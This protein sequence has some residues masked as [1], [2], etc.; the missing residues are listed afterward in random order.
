MPVVMPAGNVSVSR[1][2]VPDLDA[3][4]CVNVYFEDA[5]GNFG[6]TPKKAYLFKPIGK[7]VGLEGGV[8]VADVDE[9]ISNASIAS[10]VNSFDNYELDSTVEGSMLSGE[11]TKDSGDG[12]NMLQLKAY[13]RRKAFTAKVTYH[14]STWDKV[15][16]IYKTETLGESEI[17]GPGRWGEKLDWDPLEYFDMTVPDAEQ[18]FREAKYTVSFSGYYKYQDDSSYVERWPNYRFTENE[19]VKNQEYKTKAP[20][21]YSQKDNTTYVNVYYTEPIPDEHFILDVYMNSESV[22]KPGG[23]NAY[24]DFVKVTIDGT[25]YNVRLVDKAYVHNVSFTWNEES[26]PDYPGAAVFAPNGYQYSD[27]PIL[28]EGFTDVTTKVQ[29]METER[30]G[31]SNY[32]YYTKGE[33][34][35]VVMPDNTFVSQSQMILGNWYHVSFSDKSIV[36]RLVKDYADK[37]KVSDTITGVYINNNSSSGIRQT[38]DLKYPDRAG[39][40]TFNFRAKNTIHLYHYIDGQDCASESG[41]EF[42]EGSTI[43]LAALTKCNSVVPKK[44]YVFAFYNDSAYTKKVTAEKVNVTSSIR[45]YGKSV[46]DTVDYH[47]YAHYELPDSIGEVRYV[48][49]DM[50]QEEGG[51]AY[52][53]VGETRYPLTKTENSTYKKDTIIDG[54]EQT[55]EYDVIRTTYTYNGV[56]VLVDDVYKTYTNSTISCNYTEYETGYEGLEY[57]EKNTANVLN[58]YCE[59]SEKDLAVYFARKTFTLE[60]DENTEGKNVDKSVYRYGQEITVKNA[61]KDG[62]IF[63]G[64]DWS[65]EDKKVTEPSTT[66]ESDGVK[67]A[68]PL[69]NVVLKAK[70]KKDT[71]EYSIM[72]YYQTTAKT[73]N[74]SF[75]DSLKDITPTD[76]SI[77]IAGAEAV[78]GKVYNAEGDTALAVAY[79]DGNTTYYYAGGKKNG[80]TYQVEDSALVMAVEKVSLETELESN[81]AKHV[82][83]NSIFTYTN[84]T[85][86]EDG[87]LTK[88]P[89]SETFKAA[90]GM[91]LEYYYSRKGG[92]SVRLIAKATDNQEVTATLTSTGENGAITY[93]EAVDLTQHTNTGYTFQG[94][95][96]AE[97]VLENTSGEEKAM[98]DWTLKADWESLTKLAAED[99]MGLP[100][101]ND[102]TVVAVYKPV[103]VPGGTISIST[104]RNEYVY[105]YAADT[106][107]NLESNVT[108]EDASVTYI[109]GYTWKLGEQVVGSASTYKF[110]VAMNKGNYNYT[111]TIEIARRDNNRS[112]Y[113]TSSSLGIAVGEYQWDCYGVNYEGIYDGQEH[114]ID[115]SYGTVFEKL[116]EGTDYKVYYSETEAITGEN[117]DSMV[118]AKTAVNKPITKKD[119]KVDADGNVIPYTVYFY[120]KPIGEKAANYMGASGSAYITIHPRAIQA[121]AKKPFIKVFDDD[122]K[123]NGS[124]TT[125]GNDKYRLSYGEQIEGQQVEYYQVVG[126]L[127]ADQAEQTLDFD[128]VYN[129]KHV[130]AGMITLS[131][132]QL[133][134]KDDPSKVNYNYV[135][136]TGIQ[137]TG[138]IQTKELKVVWKDSEGD[139]GEVGKDDVGNTTVTYSY[140]G[141]THLPAVAFA[142]E[143]IT[144]LTISATGAESNSGGHIATAELSSTDEDV[145]V[146]D[147]HISQL[148]C[149][150]FVTNKS[151]VIVP[152]HTTVEYDQKN[153]G[154]TTFVVKKDDGTEVADNVTS[155]ASFTL[156]GVEYALS[157]T[158]VANEDEAVRGYSQAGDYAFK[159]TKMRVIYNGKDVS[160]NF[161]LATE[162]GTLTITKKPVEVRGITAE[163][164]VYNG[165]TNVV[166]GFDTVTFDGIVEGDTLEL[167][168]AQITG[169]F[170][171]KTVDN[172]KEV[173][174]TIPEAALVG[175]SANNYCL[176]TES[177]ASVQNVTATAHITPADLVIGAKEIQMNY[178]EDIPFGV[179]I[180]EELLDKKED[181]SVGGKLTF[182]VTDEEENDCGSISYDLSEIEGCSLATLAD[183]LPAA[184]FGTF[185]LTCGTYNIT[186]DVSEMTC[187]DYTF[188]Q[189]EVSATLTIAKKQVTA[190]VKEGTKLTKVYDGTN[191]VLSSQLEAIPGV[192][193]FEGVAEADQA[194]FGFAAEN[195][196]EAEY[197]DAHVEAADKI[198]LTN[199]AINNDNYELVSTTLDIPAEITPK[200]LTIKAV[201]KSITYGA[202][203]TSIRYS[204]SL[205]DLIT[206][207]ADS[208][209]IGSVTYATD[210][211]NT[212]VDK[213]NAGS[214]YKIQ[215]TGTTLKTKDYQITETKNGTLTVNKAVI[216]VK[217]APTQTAIDE[218]VAN[219]SVDAP[220]AM[221][222]GSAIKGSWFTPVYSGFKYGELQSV[223]TGTVSYR[224]NMPEPLADITVADGETETP[225][226]AGDFHINPVVDGLSASNYRFE[227]DNTRE[228]RINKLN[229][230]LVDDSI[231]VKDKVYD[232]TKTVALEQIVCG[233]GNDGK[234]PGSESYSYDYFSGIQDWDK[235]AL[236]QAHETGLVFD[237]SEGKTEYD[238]KDAGERTVSLSYSL[239]TYM[240]IR[241]NLVNPQPTATSNI[242][243]KPLKITAV[244]DKSEITYGDSIPAFSNKYDS[245]AGDETEAVLELTAESRTGDSIY[246]DAN[247]RAVWTCDYLAQENQYSQVQSYDVIPSGYTV[248]AN[249]NYEVSYEKGTF[250]VKDTKL[251]SPEVTITAPGVVKFGPSKKIGDVDI[252]HYEMELY[253]RT[254]TEDAGALIAITGCKDTDGNA[255]SANSVVPEKEYNLLELIRTNGAG[256]YE[257]RVTAVAK[258]D[259]N[260]EYINVKSSEPGVS[261]A[262]YATEVTLKLD[263]TDV[264][265]LSAKTKYPDNISFTLKDV[266]KNVGAGYPSYVF[267]EGEKDIPIKVDMRESAATGYGWSTVTSTA[268]QCKLK[269]NPTTSFDKDNL[270]REYSD[271]ADIM[272]TSSS[273]ESFAVAKAMEIK[274]KLVA[275][276]AK[277][278]AVLSITNVEE[279]TGGDY[280]YTVDGLSTTIKYNYNVFPQFRI[281]ISAEEGDTVATDKYTY[282]CHWYRKYPGNGN[283]IEYI[284]DATDAIKDDKGVY[285]TLTLPA[286]YIASRYTIACEITAKRNDNDNPIVYDTSV[287]MGPA[288]R[289]V[290]T[291]MKADFKANVKWNTTIDGKEFGWT[292]GE[293][294]GTV[295]TDIT[296]EEV[297]AKNIAY[298]YSNTPDQGSTPWTLTQPAAGWKSQMPTDAGTWYVRAYVVP[299][300]TNYSEGVTDA[301]KFVIKKAKLDKPDES[302]IQLLTPSDTVPYGTLV[303][304]PVDNIYE[305]ASSD[306]ANRA[307]MVTPK[308]QVVVS[309][310]NG[311]TY[312]E[313][314]TYDNL[315]LA[316]GKT[317]L[318][319]DI[320]ETLTQKG[321]YRIAIT[322]AANSSNGK[323]NCENS[324]V[325]YYYTNVGGEIVAAGGIYEKTYDGTP[326]V[327]NAQYEGGVAEGTTYQWYKDGKAVAGAT[328]DTYDVKDV[329]QSGVYFC[330]ATD[331]GNPRCTT[332]QTVTIHKAALTITAKDQQINYKQTP[333]DP[334]TDGL[335]AGTV[336]G[337]VTVNGFVPGE[338]FGNLSGTLKY[339]YLHKDGKTAYNGGKPDPAGEYSIKPSGYTSGNYNITYV[340]GKLTVNPIDD[341]ITVTPVALEGTTNTVHNYDGNAVTQSMFTVGRMGTGTL[342]YTYYKKKADVDAPEDTALAGAPKDAGDYYI[343]VT[344]AEDNN[345]NESK[346]DPVAFTIGKKTIDITVTPGEKVY[347]NQSVTTALFTI[348]G[349]EGDGTLTYTYYKKKA[350]GDG[351]EDTALAE[352]PTDAG[353]YYVVVKADASA[354]HHG[355]QSAAT[356]FTILKRPIIVRAKHK[357]ISYKEAAANDGVTYEVVDG[358][359]ESGF[360]TGENESVFVGTLAFAYL[361]KGEHATPIPYNP[362]TPDPAGE[363]WIRPSGYTSDNYDIRFVD[364][365]LKVNPIKDTGLSITPKAKE[366]NKVAVNAD[367]FE[368]NKTGTGNVILRYYKLAG[369]EYQMIDAPVNAGT[370]Y[371]KAIMAADNNY[372]QTETEYV[373]FTITPASVTITA[374]D[375][376][377]YYG[378]PVAAVTAGLTDGTI[379]EG[380]DLQIGAEVEVTS[381]S[382]VGTYTIKPTY[383]TNNT[384]YAVTTVN[385]TYTIT[386]HEA[387]QILGVNNDGI[388]CGTKTAQVKDDN[389]VSVKITKQE[390]LQDE[391]LGTEQ[392]VVNVTDFY[393]TRVK[394]ASYELTGTTYGTIYTITVKDKQNKAGDA[395][396]T[397]YKVTIYD[398]HSFTNYEDTELTTKKKAMCDHSCGAE[399]YS[400]YDWGSVTWDY[401]YEY[402]VAGSTDN[403]K[404][405]QGVDA[406]ATYAKV[407]FVQQQTGAV[408]ATKIVNCQ[409]TCGTNGDIYTDTKDFVFDKYNPSDGTQET[410][411]AW[412]PYY[413]ENQAPYTYVIRVTPIDSDGKLVTDYK[414][415]SEQKYD[416]KTDI[417]FKATINYV[418]GCFDVQWKVTL[419]EL[420][421]ADGTT[422]VPEGIFVKVLFAYNEDANDAEDATGYQ[423]ISQQVGPTNR[424]EYCAKPASANEDGTY[425]Y[426]GSYPVWKFKGGTTDSYYHRVQVVGYVHNGVYYDISDMKYKSPNTSD[427]TKH[428]IYYAANFVGDEDHGQA[429]GVIEYNLNGMKM[430]ALVFDYNEGSDTTNHAV[431]ASRSVLFA[432]TYG[433][434]ITAEQIAAI[435]TSR[436]HYEFLGWFDASTGGNKVTEITALS[437]TKTVYAHW[438]EKVEPTG[439]ISIGEDTWNE[440]AQSETTKYYNSAKQVTITAADDGRDT[441]VINS[442]VKS[443]QYYTAASLMS[444]TQLAADS[445]A[446]VDYEEPFT[447]DANTKC[448]V[449]ARVEDKS[450]N[451]EYLSTDKLVLDNTNPVITGITEEMKVCG[452]VT[453]N[454]TETNLATVTVDGV[455]VTSL[456]ADNKYT[457]VPDTTKG[458]KEAQPHIVVVKDQSGNTVTC[459]FTQ[460]KEHAFENYNVVREENESHPAIH[461][462]DCENGCGAKDHIVV[463]SGNIVWD[464]AYSYTND[465]GNI[466]SGILG[467]KSGQRSTKAKVVLKQNSVEVASKIVSVESYSEDAD[468]KQGYADYI[469]DEDEK[470]PAYDSK[471]N[472]YTYTIEVHPLLE[473]DSVADDFSVAYNYQ[474]ATISYN[475]ECFDAI[476]TVTL[477]HDATIGNVVPDSINVKV[478]FAVDNEHEDASYEIISQHV[479]NQG[480]ICVKKEALDHTQ[481]IYTGSYPVWKYQAGK[482]DK[483]SYYHRIEIVGYTVEGVYYSVDPGTYRSAVED[484][485]VYNSEYDE[486][487]HVMEL[488]VDGNVEIPV[489]YLD[490]NLEGAEG[491][492]HHILADK[493]DG[494]VTLEQLTHANPAKD[495]YTFLGWRTES[496]GGDLITEDLTHLKKPVTLYGYWKQTAVISDLE[497]TS[498]VYDGTAVAAPTFTTNHENG[499]VTI[500]YKKKD[501]ADSTYTDEAP[502]DAG[503][504]TVRVSVDTDD[505]YTK[506][507]DTTD[508]EITKKP[509]QLV[510]EAVDRIYDGTK[511]VEVHASVATGIDGESITVADLVGTMADV[512][513]GVDKT[514]TVNCSES[515]MTT[516]EGTSLEN[517]E[518]TA[519]GSTTV[520]IAA[521]PVQ[522]TP[523]DAS[524]HIGKPDP[525]SLTYTV[526]ALVQGE[527]L[528]DVTITRQ[529]GE[530]AGTYEI[531]ADMTE[532]ANPDYVVDLTAKGSFEITP[533]EFTQYVSDG[534]ATCTEDGTKTAIC[535]V[536]GCEETDT[537]AD[538]DSAL[539]HKYKKEA[540]FSWA[541]DYSAATATFVCERDASHTVTLDCEVTNTKGHQER[542]FVAKVTFEGQEYS[543]EKRKPEV[544][545]TTITEISDVS[546]VYD[547]AAVA[548]PAYTTNHEDGIVTIEYKK[549]DAADST[550]TAEAPKDAGEYIVRI[551]IQED[552]DYTSAEETATFTI[553]K[554]QI[555]V[556]VEAVNRIYN[557][558]KA[559]E[560]KTTIDTGV[561]GES[562]TVNGAT[563]SMVDAHAGV[564]KEVRVE[565][566]KETVKVETNMKLDNYEIQYPE[567]TT[568]TITAKFVRVILKDGEKHIGTADPESFGYD[569][570]GIVEGEKL[571]QITVSRAEGE[572]A[573]AYDV[574]A[575]MEQGANPNYVVDLESKATFTIRD[576][577]YTEYVSNQDATCTEDGTKT[578][579][580]DVD[581]C[582]VKDTIADVDSKLGHDYKKEAKF[583]WSSDYKEATAYFQ[584]N[585]DALHVQAVTCVVKVEEKDNETDYYAT[586]EF[587]GETY[588]DGKRVVKDIVQSDD[589]DIDL[590]LVIALNEGID[591][592]PESLEEVGLETEEKIFEKM[593]E[594]AIE[595]NSQYDERKSVLYDVELQVS[596]D[597]GTT[598]D[599]ATEDEFPEEGVTVTLDYPEGTTKKSHNFVITHMFT[600][601]FHGCKPGEVENPAVTKTDAGLQF[602]IHSLSPI[603]ISWKDVIPVQ[604]IKPDKPQVTINKLEEKVQLNVEVLP[605]DADDKTIIW[606]SSDPSV[607]EVDENGV[608]I[609]HK[610]GEATITATAADGT[611]STQIIVIAKD[612][613]NVKPGTTNP[614]DSKPNRPAPIKPN[615]EKD[616][617]T[618]AEAVSKNSLSLNAKLKV[619]QKGSK[620]TISWGKVKDADGYE[621]YAQYCGK[622]FKKKPNKSINHNNVTRAVITKINGK[623]LNL[624]KNYKIYII[625]YKM[626]DGKKETIAKT[627]TAHIVGRKNKKGTNVKK[628][629][630]KKSSFKLKRNKTAKIKG[631]TVLVDKTKKPLSDRHAKELRFVSSDPTIAT[632]NEK[633]KIK[634]RRKGTCIIYVYARNGYAKKVKVTV[635]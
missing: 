4:F 524:K 564:D 433:G 526:D 508:F 156:D 603:M 27:E 130:D 285:T 417:G 312:E 198:V 65:I 548:A 182:Y 193:E 480:V 343:V 441:G 366:Y 510:Y 67:F 7:I 18:S 45:V 85:C 572:E 144:N 494:K 579:V 163:T 183:S 446:W 604:E 140:N 178:G 155:G 485:M 394:E 275:I 270:V 372:Q 2:Y 254:N 450:G 277:V 553:A 591:E 306:A 71:L 341:V 456:M 129:S 617:Y 381:A 407:E 403:E 203:K 612:E 95:Y 547:G 22:A 409:E 126:V 389:L 583:V 291:V 522:V 75:V 531:T 500:E 340:N 599:I 289:F 362:S 581:G 385:A 213:R 475:P 499:S 31:K 425:T 400:A 292:Y 259:K 408:L 172:D 527:S 90:F 513:V 609:A 422:I 357:D 584:C 205:T 519:P 80:E 303:W 528:T 361:H 621:L 305:N 348:S 173:T 181:V 88:N 46:K 64:W 115:I 79:E 514:V 345:Y 611:V 373:A 296:P 597:G 260:A 220:F 215:I 250:T 571:N 87:M 537:V 91:V 471:G 266:T 592:I 234:T 392:E 451:V 594:H 161:V 297:T 463:R 580:C 251:E 167:D 242:T 216:K 497:A 93:G 556:A 89:G 241:Y 436:P 230:K 614:G 142:D 620:I 243:R 437:Q 11:V 461:E 229:L 442:G 380:D 81:F 377:S 589:E 304:D 111:C 290:V 558:D 274:V 359:E 148:N 246:T 108:L 117:L 545:E 479:G 367:D 222:Y 344:Q 434:A 37:F 492:I 595:I 262:I 279:I 179:V 448:Y 351:P 257:V 419:G 281:D 397:T 490:Y 48:T 554:K 36:Y 128:A 324:D 430:P 17:V 325:A 535:D 133:V 382:E 164:K 294:R 376:A 598:W 561:E 453:F 391:S 70:W 282:S 320:A 66:E 533:H 412:I 439:S 482:A 322:A 339:D 102:V 368:I 567:S 187:K 540:T 543:D 206:G 104:E 60:V 41:H 342:T 139:P 347:D 349:M 627:I 263:E 202:A 521:R 50:I 135:F 523:T 398:K 356:A 501:A 236:K 131:N 166:L 405:V 184:A 432:A 431:R 539:G 473:D 153:H 330:I 284:G 136:N 608:A 82:K 578:A 421:V 149:E 61:K 516:A 217:V 444:R 218:K 52:F 426:T 118:S 541:E 252:D 308:Y 353:D 635:K 25:S 383:D 428:T 54:G 28:R 29:A 147:Y 97:A 364:G 109:K 209:V 354:N 51:S 76:A 43:P 411:D 42:A 69:S 459:E 225:K 154:I 211:D 314:K 496:N 152:E 137:L 150:F 462:A 239:N 141:K 188:Q 331:N 77:S 120:V 484:Y 301:T 228:L 204:Y 569:V 550:Y 574:T 329:A 39:R 593:L 472:E 465:H 566:A 525:D 323:D 375:A 332:K 116:K 35:Y 311:D 622:N 288:G 30:G 19:Q 630:V 249:G 32:E 15:N 319:L 468:K 404:G 5:N 267:V 57:D 295:N 352:A 529:S 175:A 495:G 552:D 186:A 386:D 424:G 333:V 420:P 447:L 544:I 309:R 316:S 124:L 255:F 489:V 78:S 402:S 235:V 83:A 302:K 59:T 160:D 23:D 14:Y 1:K 232:A 63:D 601:D 105:G 189:S 538:D 328:D 68:M 393:D 396:E 326:I 214:D 231:H 542:I 515:D 628:V 616:K 464:Y 21:Y 146:H 258:V 486:A 346:S 192:V 413:D 576:H 600:H 418:P 582:Q 629:V 625:A 415:K 86:K 618:S 283:K 72:H 134:N 427:H 477:N 74:K 272:S 92:Y 488:N 265:A 210:Y 224:F 269:N 132:L 406:R 483:S 590:R 370:Y 138:E 478:L 171:N 358:V 458:A 587:E 159:A 615:S 506:V 440:L 454:V 58:E 570:E 180:G 240:Q 299:E 371:V 493:M 226:I 504:Y 414:V 280:G 244:P 121:V 158:A 313:V 520:S 168:T 191:E 278:K 268:T 94:W 248:G 34:L 577:I 423:I 8:D 507:V 360:A 56:D 185:A 562:I 16:K 122:D 374:Q 575:K 127:E 491:T 610:E 363:Y 256:N 607:V 208:D 387:P 503:K 517:Y 350:D 588:Q 201:S 157:A 532:G 119:V 555:T 9:I 551:Q 384:N 631:T 602:V 273:A 33:Y 238:N 457:I 624:K 298:Y 536:D 223:I 264:P 466:S 55:L 487:D 6:T 596:K 390:K 549:K 334:G 212:V 165:N 568:V 145:D 435:T 20:V 194:T 634:A 318:T 467:S 559:V 151:L 174:I 40:F 317:K 321:N 199:M 10:L 62:Y 307:S 98:E 613:G 511:N 399:D 106:I 84:A 101:Y 107:K 388:Y 196:F 327:L 237:V 335:V 219:T 125:P 99:T 162:A 177:D 338:S 619:Q 190:K 455:D 13:Y 445:V 207:E 416:A 626:I 73:Y 369:E 502:K 429:S 557:G 498:K 476:W 481:Y 443:V 438:R 563:G 337:G 247:N 200:A 253:K 3:K 24:N 100:I 300:S 47:R 530:T 410:G 310:Q 96:M 505:D 379:Y 26:Y 221:T 518:I 103:A 378:K 176:K 546:K 512:H 44:G 573:G 286:G 276:E 395:N 470:L 605:E 449:Y 355:A 113:V 469:F 143:S 110:P 565:Y 114:G 293:A 123:V 460:F 560:V 534:N 586:A 606:S 365:R 452:A 474:E 633:G 336:V 233:A 261:K 169:A 170:G 287:K 315:E 53:T 197:N 112:V 49:K 227:A 271:T 245:F 401:A 195:P 632:V 38:S 585:R 509:V 12:S 623:K